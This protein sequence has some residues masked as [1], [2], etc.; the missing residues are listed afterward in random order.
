MVVKKE[1]GKTNFSKNVL[2]K[3]KKK[4]HT[5]DPNKKSIVSADI[6]SYV[7]LKTK[8]RHLTKV[9]ADKQ[10]APGFNEEDL[11]QKD[12]DIGDEE[13]KQFATLLPSPPNGKRR[14]IDYFVK[15]SVMK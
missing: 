12:T 5:L 15:S 9:L 6:D 8:T 10:E 7:D 11:L 2:S 14:F 4:D 1:N 13:A 3:I